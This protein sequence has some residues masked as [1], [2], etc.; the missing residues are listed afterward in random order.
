V[1]KPAETERPAVVNPEEGDKE[2]E[3]D[4]GFALKR[5]AWFIQQRAYP[6]AHIPDGARWKAL[7]QKAELD[8]ARASAMKAG[9]AARPLDAFTSAVW[10]SDG[11]KPQAYAANSTAYSGRAT[12][13]AIN[14]VTPTTIYLGTAGGGV[15]KTT[16][17]G[18]TWTPLTDQQSS[19]AIGALA[20]DPVNPNNIYVG[21][22]EPDLS[23]DSYYGQGLLKSTDG[24]NTWTLIRPP[25]TSGN[26]TSTTFTQISIQPG[27]S[28][29]ILASTFIGVYRSADAGNT[30]TKVLPQA[31]SAVIFDNANSSV[32]YAGING[33]YAGSGATAPVYKS[34]DG[35]VTWNPAPGSTANPLP[36]ESAVVRT[37]LVEDST[38]AN[39]YAAL[40]NGNYTA[41]GTL[42]RSTDGGANWTKLSSPSSGDGIDWYRDGIAVVPKTN[43]DVLFTGGVN[44]YQ[45]LDGGVTWKATTGGSQWADQHYFVVS[46]DGSKVY[47]ADDGGIFVAASPASANPLFTSLNA[48]IDTMTFYPGF[49][50]IANQPNSALAGAQDHGIDLYSGA[51]LWTYGD[52][53]HWC[54]DGGSVFVDAQNTHAYAH[55]QGG[56]ANWIANASGANSPNNYVSAQSGINTGNTDR[57]PWVADIKGD[58]ENLAIV[59]TATNHLYQSTNYAGTWTSIS[60]DLTAGSS[61]ISTIA[62]A[63]TSS[64]VVYTGASD[65]TIEV[66][67][68]ALAGTGATWTKLSGLPNRGISKIV[69]MPDSAQDVYAAIN[70]FGTGHVFHSTN[71]GSTWTDLSGNLPDTPIDSILVDP[72]LLNTIYAATDTGVYYTTNNGTTW[73]TLGTGLPNVVVQDI[74]MYSP[75]RTIRVITHGRGA[76]DI[77]VPAVG[78]VDSAT[79]LT[80]AAQ[81]VGST[82]AAQTV[83]LT[84][85]FSSTAVPIASI[86]VTGNFAETNNCGTLLASGATCTVSVTFSPVSVASLTGTLTVMS[87]SGNLSV[88]LSGTGLGVPLVTLSGSS[89]TFASQ[90]AGIASAAE[91]VT[92]TNG[93]SAALTGVAI[94]LTGTN[95]SDFAQTNTCGT[96]LAVGAN[97]SVAV[98]FTPGATGSRSATLSIADNATNS[99]QTIALTGTGSAPYAWTAMQSSATVTPGSSATFTVQLTAAAGTTLSAAVQV[100]CG[101]A[102][103][104]ATCSVSPGSVAAG[105]SSQAVTVTVT[106]AAPT[107][108]ALLQRPLEHRSESPLVAF[109][110]VAGLG[111][112][113]RRKRRGLW[114]ALLSI[115]ALASAA[116][117]NG[118]GKGNS[119]NTGS[120]GTPQGSYTLTVTAQ[121]TIY[122]TT[123]NLTLTVN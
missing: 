33:V 86:G 3:A 95:G 73:A 116:M 64:N 48:N 90:P 19:L 69:V 104:L 26:T 98:V 16:D 109:A 53:D 44:I 61:T 58:P 62:V 101:G 10:T 15:W 123:Q 28:S 96:S 25:F 112:L 21:T 27:N 74:L 57:V 89:L 85:N 32:A 102:P 113:A 79:S 107:S 4:E 55:C 66:T 91:N 36:A 23:V 9:A 119:I 115:A 108:G 83:T 13:I 37:A 88:S 54:G 103:S 17:G 12:V 35:G 99:P 114:I 18:N 118:C 47:V 29:V 106:T 111:L 52:N 46:P 24:G 60:P 84:N 71:G 63:P 11:P 50:I 122:T 75:T 45:S 93:G 70:G 59:Y 81:N 77:A 68:N 43:P 1:S 100:S 120:A 51:A 121:S 76:W 87:S 31:S 20:V 5:Q 65:G 82:S 22:G 80:F 6:N 2:G 30:W 14:P 49:S 97:C 92:V 41:P 42:Y 67:T 110:A 94:T 56:G 8:H 40:A 38:G 105:A 117:L 34:T 39:L 72:A 7:Q 78:F